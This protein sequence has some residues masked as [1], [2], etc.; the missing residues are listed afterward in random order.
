[1]WQ[2]YQEHLQALEALHPLLYER[3]ITGIV[4]LG[5]LGNEM[6]VNAFFND[7]IEDRPQLTDVVALGLEYLE[8][9][10]LMRKAGE[11]AE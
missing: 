6:Q 1:L 10:S 9:N 8:I 7:Y 5:G 2:W 4:P 3:V 11:G